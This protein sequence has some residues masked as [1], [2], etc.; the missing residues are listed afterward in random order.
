[1]DGKKKFGF[2]ILGWQFLKQLKV[3]S[4]NS[5]SSGHVVGTHGEYSH[6]PMAWGTEAMVGAGTQLT[7]QTGMRVLADGGNAMD[8]AVATAFAAGVLEPSAHYTLGGE[9]AMLYYEASSKRVLS[10]V[11][12][13]WSAGTQSE[14]SILF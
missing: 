11:G 14:I 8:A 13:G 1:M 5:N 4:M 2:H 9:V 7:A 3:K 10:V 6:R 12:Q